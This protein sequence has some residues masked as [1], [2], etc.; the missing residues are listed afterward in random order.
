[1]NN[2]FKVVIAPQLGVNDDSA[3]LHEWLFEYGE[4][5]MKDE[6]LCYVETTKAS[7]EIHCEFN[8]HLVPLVQPGDTVEV[9]QP[10]ALIVFEKND[11]KNVL[12]DYKGKE[13][14]TSEPVATKKALQLA[15]ENNINIEELKDF[16]GLI[17]TKDVKKFIKESTSDHTVSLVEVN[18]DRKPVI[19]YG[20]GKGGVTVFET[21]EIGG[22]YEVAAFIDDK[23]TGS[24][25]G[26]PVYSSDQKDFLLKNKIQ[27]I[28]IAIANGR[29]RKKI[30][31]M[32]EDYGFKII[33][34]IH[35]NSHLSHSVSLGKGNHIKS[36][37]IIE[38][39]TTVGDYNIIDNGTIIAHDNNIGDGSHLAPGCC[40]GSSISIGDF[41]ILGIG[42][43]VS[44]NIKIGKGCIISLNSSV[45]NNLADNS[46]VEGV[47][48]KII[49]KTNI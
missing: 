31:A 23:I 9:N 38:T 47:P 44:T 20:A 2:K 18:K 13:I 35:P 30:G 46:L 7:I 40:L 32:F 49:G 14:I 28:F 17:R 24:V 41:S 8:G 27:Y 26:K 34:A 4:N 6:L 33:N 45:T 22:V 16:K 21:L 29:I 19:I 25:L 12:S 15:K 1:M 10:I 39:N 3:I 42:S 5:V 37:A 36:G 48:G 11:I 43:S